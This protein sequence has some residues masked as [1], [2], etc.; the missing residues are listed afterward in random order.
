MAIDTLAYAK[1]LE[2]A[3]VGRQAAEAQ[4]EALDAALEGRV[5][6]DLVTKSDLAEA[7]HD[8]RQAMH[9]QTLRHVGFTFMAVGIVDAILFAL[10]RVAH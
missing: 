3:G 4:A 5:L 2:A 8:I 1:R 10:L 7:V 9:E 6:P